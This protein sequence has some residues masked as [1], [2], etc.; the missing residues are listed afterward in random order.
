MVNPVAFRP[1]TQEDFDELMSICKEYRTNASTLTSSILSDWMHS[2]RSKQERGDITLAAEIIRNILKHVDKKY[3]QKI[4][5]ANAK[6]IIEEMTYQKEDL[7]FDEL[8]KRIME[9]NNKENKIP[10]RK[11]ARKDAVKF[12][13]RHHMEHVWSVIQC[14]MYAKMFELIGET[15]V[16]HSI[17][18][19]RNSFSFEVIRHQ[20]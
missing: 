14:T 13:Q 9:W 15:I 1:R 10:L 12:I 19:D 5:H 7:D 8:A 18:Y 4:A 2:R 17:K 20:D 16:P 6:Y 3:Y 11:V